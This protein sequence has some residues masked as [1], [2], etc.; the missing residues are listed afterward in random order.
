MGVGTTSSNGDEGDIFSDGY[1]GFF[2]TLIGVGATSSNGDEGDKFS[3]GNLGVASPGIGAGER[4]KRQPTLLVKIHT[5]RAQNTTD[6]RKSLRATYLLMV[7]SVL[8]TYT[9]TS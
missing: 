2:S 4:L 6:R 7:L 5:W 1:L 3:D 8:L 9:L